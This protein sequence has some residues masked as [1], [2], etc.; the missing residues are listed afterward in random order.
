MNSGTPKQKE[1]LQPEPKQAKPDKKPDKPHKLKVGDRIHRRVLGEIRSATITACEGNDRYYFY[2]TDY[3]AGSC[4]DGKDEDNTIESLLAEIEAE[5]HNW[6]T[7]H[8]ENLQHRITVEY[9]PRKVD[10]Y[11]MRAQIGIYNNMLYYQ[12]AG[13]YAFCEAF[14]SEAE[15]LKAYKEHKEQILK[16]EHTVLAEELPMDNLYWSNSANCYAQAEFVRPYKY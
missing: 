8:P 6:N 3:G 15:L 13:C 14:K 16:S 4:F 11:V 1:C 12:E 9:P 2:R 7:I 10:G 5:K